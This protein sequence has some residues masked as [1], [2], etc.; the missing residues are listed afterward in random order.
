MND[1][2]SHTLFTNLIFTIFYV[3][4]TI[5]VEEKMNNS[6]DIE[7]LRVKQ[8]L[9][10]SY[11][12]S[13]SKKYQK[14]TNICE[15]F[16]KRFPK[17]SLSE[18]TKESYVEGKVLNGQS[19]KT[20]FCYWV[21]WGTTALGRMQGARSNKFGL[22][23]EKATQEYKYIRKYINENIAFEA[24]K[25]NI[26]NLVELGSKK[27]LKLIDQID[28][29]PMFKGKI[30]FLYYPD[31]YLNIFSETYIDYF[32]K[33]LFL[34]NENCKKTLVQKREVLLDIKEHDSVMLKWNMYEFSDFLYMS[35][36]NPLKDKNIPKELVDYYDDGEYPD[37][38][39]VNIE[40]LST[41]FDYENNIDT[42]SY[43]GKYNS[44][45]ID[46][47][48]ENKRKRKIGLQGELVVLNYE[49]KQ[50]IQQGLNKLADQVTQISSESQS[51]G[52]DILSFDK[53]GKEK[54]IEVKSTNKI[55]TETT[56]FYISNNEVDK[57]KI[58][59]D[60]YLYL[61]FEVKSKKPK[62]IIL[63]N[64]CKHYGKTIQL[65]PYNYRVIIKLKKI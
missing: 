43:S 33:Q 55:F 56:T 47:E 59:S 65:V 31:K 39:T 9:F 16:Q 51:A 32:L 2:F 5:Q 36:G 40:I 12:Q 3:S 15:Q 41:R 26:I 46:F 60:Y 48:L 62:V 17:S 1:V 61:V 58:L 4:Q 30:L 14:L 7:D 22:Y 25:E 23:I 20:T 52:Y 37:P 27:D 63:D 13:N 35:Y 24:I 50:L 34:Y 28:L 6:I 45:S 18:L 53:S 49:K 54:R 29:S 38:K 10:E 64:P 44:N 21:E 8:T 11:R 57:S 19:D 42:L